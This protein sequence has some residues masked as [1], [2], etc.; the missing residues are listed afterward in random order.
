MI[1]WEKDSPAKII[2]GHCTTHF[3]Y[4]RIWEEI[5]LRFQ[6]WTVSSAVESRG[7]QSQ[8]LSAHSMGTRNPCLSRYHQL[9]CFH[10]WT[11][12]Q[13]RE[14][15]PT[16]NIFSSKQERRHSPTKCNEWIRFRE[17]LLLSSWIYCDPQSFASP[18][19][20]LSSRPISIVL[21]IS[22]WLCYHPFSCFISTH[23]HHLF[24]VL[25]CK[26]S[27]IIEMIP[28]EFSSEKNFEQ[29]RKKED[30]VNLSSCLCCHKTTFRLKC[31]L[32]WISNSLQYLWG[33]CS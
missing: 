25:R 4:L 11:F 7:N 32:H 29:K 6:M 13:M 30:V 3:V 27:F 18:S 33:T 14:S 12:P 10:Y 24:R 21:D 9:M 1:L 26:G 23:D 19:F 2:E 17:G 20:P 5:W 22:F 15:C 31:T 28:P 8:T 16:V